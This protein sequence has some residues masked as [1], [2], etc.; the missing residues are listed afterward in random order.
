MKDY[1]TKID[2]NA[3]VVVVWK[4]L[5]D[6][7]R[8]SEWNPLVSQLTGNISEGGI[9][10]TSI[11]PLADTFQARLLSFKVNKEIVWKGK[12]GAS[13]LLAGKHYYR[14][15]EQKEDLTT[16]EHGEYFTG[17]FSNFISKKLLEKMEQ[18]FVAHNLALKERIENGR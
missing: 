15:R 8:Y 9:I 6:F 13:F 10:H 5:T 1:H 4:A 17:I 18:A 16:L 3:S 12:R 14:L 11:V 7:E 2:I